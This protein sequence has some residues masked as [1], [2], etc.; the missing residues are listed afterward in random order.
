MHVDPSEHWSIGVLVGGPIA[1]LV[2]IALTLLAA[3]AFRRRHHDDYNATDLSVLAWCSAGAAVVVVVA[4]VLFFYPF[5]AEYH[6][7]REVSGTVATTNSR[8]LSGDNGTDQKFVVTF[9]GSGQQFGCSDTRC[10]G[11]QKGDDLTLTCKRSWQWFGTPGYDCNFVAL[12]G[13]R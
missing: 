9:D 6:Q 3:W 5:K 8:F 11:V 4:S 2:F 12:G 7:W 10:A 1:A 13:A